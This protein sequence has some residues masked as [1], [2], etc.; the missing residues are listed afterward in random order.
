LAADRVAR[1]YLIF[2]PQIYGPAGPPAVTS[3]PPP[4]VGGRSVRTDLPDLGPDVVMVL[5]RAWC[6]LTRRPRAAGPG[7]RR[8]RGGPSSPPPSR[9]RC[10]APR[11]PGST[12]PPAPRAA[13]SGRAGRAGPR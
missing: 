1:L 8:I 7:S 10:R 6:A 9:A 11:A 3:A 13:G 2:A 5:D 12:G 4:S